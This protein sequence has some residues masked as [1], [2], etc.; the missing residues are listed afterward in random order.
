MQQGDEEVE[1]KDQNGDDDGRLQD[2]TVMNNRSASRKPKRLSSHS[3]N[4]EA[5]DQPDREQ[6]NGKIAST[7]VF[8]ERGKTKNIQECHSTGNKGKSKATKRKSSRNSIK[9][10]P[11]ERLDETNK[12]H[13]EKSAESK[14]QPASRDEENDSSSG[15]EDIFNQGQNDMEVRTKNPVLPLYL[16]TQRTSSATHTPTHLSIQTYLPPYPPT[17]SILY[18]NSYRPI[19]TYSPF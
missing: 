11:E 16:P 1:K 12:Q 7:E 5:E 2:K 6:T 19:H 10:Q 14:T 3:G 18:S 13:G 9:S 15:D 4:E 8:P 17:C